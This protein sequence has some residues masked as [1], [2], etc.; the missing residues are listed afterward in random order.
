MTTHAGVLQAA[1]AA[2]GVAFGLACAAVAQAGDAPAT[3]RVLA[4]GTVAHDALDAQ[5]ETL[6]GFGS[7]L[8]LDGA[9]ADHYLALPDRGP[10]DGSI[11]YRPR[12]H[13]LRVTRDPTDATRLHTTVEA[14]VILLDEDG[15]PFTG[16]A[17]DATASARADAPCLADGRRCLDPEAIVSAPDRTIYV[18]DE[19]GPF[20][21]QFERDGKLRRTLRPPEHYLPR[22]GEGKPAYGD[23]DGGQ[24]ASGRVE[25]RGFEGLALSP[26]GSELTAILQSPLAQ[27]GGKAGGLSRLLVFDAESGRAKA[28]YAYAFEDVAAANERLKLAEDDRLKAKNL[29]VSELV[30]VDRGRFLVLERDNRGLDGSAHPATAANK[31]VWLLDTAE[32]TNLLALPGQPFARG[33]GDRVEEKRSLSKALPAGQVKPVGKRLLIDMVASCAGATPPILAAALPEK[34]E[35][36]ALRPTDEAGKY[37]LL[38]ATDNDFLSPT[39]RLAGRGEVP[40]A[41][42]KRAADTLLLLFEM[43]L[44]HD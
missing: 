29:G 26:D 25:N 13:R 42:A 27:D 18:A 39:L 35:G 23:A 11:D 12:F 30:A 33:P 17:P 31:S 28:E 44:P 5:G 20:V 43:N 10:G 37:S 9:E 21:Y 8:A 2:V 38:V 16:L 14:T 15:K 40:F 3:A 32:A 41:K 1:V 36:S 22:T 7:G 34:W 19:Y 4:V 6:G 24:P